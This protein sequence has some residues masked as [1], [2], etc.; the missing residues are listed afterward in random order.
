MQ[1]YIFDIIFVSFQRTA[2]DN[3]SEE[4]EDTIFLLPTLFV[5]ISKYS[6]SI[7]LSFGNICIEFGYLKNVEEE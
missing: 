4:M 3:C 2:F 5:S 7:S 1:F 6:N